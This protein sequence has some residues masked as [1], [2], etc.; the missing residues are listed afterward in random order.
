L[1]GDGQTALV[2]SR[3][4]D[5]TTVMDAGS[6]YVFVRSGT[7]W[8]QQAKLTAADGAASDYFGSA[9]SLSSDGNTALVGS[10]RDDT[11]AGTDA[12]SAYVFVRSGSTWSQQV[13]LTAANG[14]AT[15]YLG[16]SVFLSGDGLTAL[17]G[18]YQDDTPAGA[19]AGSAY[20]FVR[21]ESSWSQQAQVTAGDGAAG[22]NLGI[23]VSLSS[24]GNT[25][26]VGSSGDDTPAGTDAGS[27]YVFGRSGGSWSLQAKL[28]AADG[29]ASDDF[30]ISVSLS[31]DGSTALVGAFFEDTPAANTGCA[32]VFVRSGSSWTQQAKLTVADGAVGDYFGCSDSLSGDGN[33]ALVGAYNDDTPAGANAGSACVFVRSGS[34]WSQL[35]KLTASDGAANDSFGSSVSLSSDGATALVGASGDDAAAG[36]N[37]GSAYVFVW[38]GSTWS[39]QSKLTAADGAFNDYFGCSVSLNSDGSA[40]LVGANGDDTLAGADAG[41]AYVFVRSDTTWS[42]QA[43]LTAADAAAADSFGFGVSLADSGDMALVG[44]MQD[45]TTAGSNAG[46]AYVFVRSGTTWNQQAK[47]TPNDGAAS[48][49]FGRSVSLSHDASTALV[50]AANDDTSAGAD[51]GS[52]YVFRLPELAEGYNRLAVQVLAGDEVRLT[53]L[54]LAGTNYA[55]DRTFNLTPTVDWVPQAT[56]PAAADNYLILTNAPDASTNNFW[57]MRS[58]P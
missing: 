46:S 23:A 40:A 36:L 31:G 26:L 16:Q 41:S 5:I 49:N 22:D 44:A 30:G 13:K 50:G 58:V 10:S 20:V 52:A 15:D 8:S 18:A 29:E 39:E 17:V 48:D 24:D 32:Y 56:N 37:V 42:E 19:N 2:G 27:A 55:L 1:S 33:T 9:V 3:L 7:N 25:A 57:R 12:G 11:L 34:S 6:A 54:G 53:Y 47:L 4:D 51:A 21:S 45:D 35:P 38:D 43:K 14:A 28:T